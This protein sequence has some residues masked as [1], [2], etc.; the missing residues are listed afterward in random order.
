MH[1]IFEKRV[2]IFFISL[3]LLMI[4]MTGP[5]SIQIKEVLYTADFSQL[6]SLYNS[7]DRFFRLPDTKLRF[8]LFNVSMILLIYTVSLRLKKTRHSSK[9]FDTAI[10]TSLFAV[11]IFILLSNKAYNIAYIIL[12]LFS[13]IYLIIYRQTDLSKNEIFLLLGYFLFFY[14][15]FVSAFLIKAELS[16]VDNYTRFLVVIPIYLTLREIKI[17][18]DYFFCI[19]NITSILI[20]MFA[21]Y[22]FIVLEQFRVVGF[23]SSAIIFGNISL[24]FA[25]ISFISLNYF[26]EKKKAILLPILGFTLAF[27]GWSL[28]GTRGAL[29]AI[30]L[31]ILLF[32][33]KKFR[34][35]FNLTNRSGIILILVSIGILIFQNNF[36]DC[37]R[38]FLSCPNVFQ[39]I[40]HETHDSH[41]MA[42]RWDIWKGA[43]NIIQENPLTGVGLKNFN[44]ELGK[45]I[46]SKKISKIRRDLKNPTAGQNHVHNQY[47]DI[48]V[49]NGIFG[50]F[51]LMYFLFINFRLF[52]K[53]LNSKV[54]E[55]RIISVLGVTMMTS[56]FSYMINHTIL[57]HQVST[58]FMLLILI[59]LLAIIRYEKNNLEFM[60]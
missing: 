55:V 9:F 2:T 51:T 20:G 27:S 46:E 31:F 11:F 14:A 52:F 56:Y 49:K 60:K 10:K 54:F 35:N 57:S 33:I 4:S 26:L 18:L 36:I 6:I 30:F 1:L 45:Q 7:H 32:A 44:K 16:E 13:V 34:S 15:A 47:L 5:P 48:Y 8:L 59:T 22:C 28:T 38:K 24:I 41:K 43:V 58:I 25:F 42:Q 21:F 53:N 50:F 3:F 29:I 39:R 23:T 19:L 40:I 37:K 17:N 12:F